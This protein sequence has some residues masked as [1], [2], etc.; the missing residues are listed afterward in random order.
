MY[1]SDFNL[2]D[3]WLF[4]HQNYARTSKQNNAFQLNWWKTLCK[5]CTVRMT[6]FWFKITS[7]LHKRICQIFRSYKFKGTTNWRWQLAKKQMIFLLT[8]V[9]LSDSNVKRDAKPLAIGL[10][11]EENVTSPKQPGSDLKNDLS[12]SEGR[13]RN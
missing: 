7:V 6:Y 12:E 10:N 5:C 11:Q 3:R 13:Q 4:A 1:L 2:R 8:Y 9:M